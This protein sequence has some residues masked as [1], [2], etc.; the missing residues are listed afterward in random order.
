MQL[1]RSLPAGLARV[2][3][4]GQVRFA[5][6]STK[7]AGPFS[8]ELSDAIDAA[9]VSIRERNDDG[10][11]VMFISDALGGAFIYERDDAARRIRNGFPELSDDAVMRGVRY[12][13][14]RAAIAI[15]PTIEE[16]R[17]MSWVHGWKE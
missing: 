2:M 1:L 3:R 8:K 5:P 6:D 9:S 15:S 17:R 12:L 10:H 14:A 11:R 4:F 7:P 16:Q 13:E